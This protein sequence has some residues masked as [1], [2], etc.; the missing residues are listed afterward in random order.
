M[1]FGE[2]NSVGQ[3]GLGDYYP[4]AEPEVIEELRN[5]GEKVVQVECG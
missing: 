2:N 5:K 3:L 1:S 4:R